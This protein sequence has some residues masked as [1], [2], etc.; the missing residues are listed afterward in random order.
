[1]RTTVAIKKH[2]FISANGVLLPRWELAFSGAVATRT[3]QL[4]NHAAND[5]VW[6]RLQTGAPIT[7]QI[8]AVRDCSGTAA[9]I[10]L[11]DMPNDDEAMAAFSLSARG[12][13]NSHA[14]AETLRQIANV[15]GQGGLWI[16]ESL[17][18]RLL[19]GVDQLPAA[20]AKTASEHRFKLTEREWEVARAIAAGASNKEVARQLQITE[21]TVKAHVSGLFTK[22]GVADRLQLALKM[23]ELI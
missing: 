5:F 13:A 16:G 22:L 6:L 17:M 18:Q 1:M 14:A 3:D 12:Y 9:L 11:S 10:V 19:I 21:R 7:Q 20:P 15:V 2:V 23:R 8:Q 4:P